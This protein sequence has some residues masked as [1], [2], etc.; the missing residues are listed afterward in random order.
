MSKKKSRKNDLLKK[1]KR[2]EGR[3]K[4][5]KALPY[6]G[7]MVYLRMIDGEIFEYLLVYKNEIYAGYN[8]IKPAKGK[9]KLTKDQQDQAAAFTLQGALATL[10]MK[11]GIKQSKKEK[12]LVKQF[13]ASRPEAEK[14]LPN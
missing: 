2:V 6:R 1:A 13:E 14:H 5:I 7:N 10:D 12:E 4:V 3:I 9:K 11:L 8:V